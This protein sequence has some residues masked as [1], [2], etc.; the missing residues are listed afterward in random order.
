[1]HN[2]NKQDPCSMIVHVK[3]PYEPEELET[4]IVKYKWYIN[5]EVVK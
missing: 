2:D 1:M 3:Q 5:E 4:N